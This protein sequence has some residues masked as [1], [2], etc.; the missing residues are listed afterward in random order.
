MGPPSGAPLRRFEWSGRMRARRTEVAR[1][2]GRRKK[3][4]VAIEKLTTIDNARSRE[5][6][7]TRA[8]TEREREPE[9]ERLLKVRSRARSRSRSRPEG[10]KQRACIGP[11]AM[12]A[13]LQSG[14]FACSSD[15]TLRRTLV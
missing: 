1:G 8:T 4:C 10:P 14:F 13:G 11:R 7:M 15:R 5:L 9:R 12:R 2:I 3:E 6:I